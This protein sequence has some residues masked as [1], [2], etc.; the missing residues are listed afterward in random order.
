MTSAPSSAAARV[1]RLPANLLDV[2]SNRL[3]TWAMGAMKTG[4]LVVVPTD[5]AGEVPR[6]MA[7]HDGAGLCVAPDA[8]SHAFLS[9]GA[10]GRLLLVEPRIE[11]PTILAEHKDKKIACVAAGGLGHRAYAIGAALYWLNESGERACA[12]AELSHRIRRLA[13][14]HDGAFLAVGHDRGVVLFKTE[15]P[16]AASAPLDMADP[17]L[18]LLWHPKERRLF[19]LSREGA[20]RCWTF[21]EGLLSS[22]ETAAGFP[23]QSRTEVAA[24]MR[25]SADGAFLAA[26]WGERALCWRLLN[27]GP[28]MGKPLPLGDAGARLVTRLAPHPKEPV[29]AVGYDDGLIVL[30]P[31][32]GRM[33]IP[34]QP[35]LAPPSEGQSTAVTGMQW[36]FD[37]NSLLIGVA[38]GFLSLFTQAS[39]ARFV[40]ER[41][42]GQRL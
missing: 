40:R 19:C 39:V 35:P 10:D 28:T 8:D 33:E 36:A 29:V 21:E 13:F 3:G 6:F 41:L 38:C 25:F 7:A 26:S 15:A 17:P 32:D 20:L 22:S 1:W 4:A 34:I 30:A 31:L 24:M 9:G 27:D 42:L 23:S 16:A 14:S 2:A 11:I 18:D 12:P 37:G 5:D